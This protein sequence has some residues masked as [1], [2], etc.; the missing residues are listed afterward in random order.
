[1]C[2]A[3]P[4]KIVDLVERDGIAMARLDYGGVT[5]EACMAY[6]PEAEVGDYVLVHVGFAI[7]RI[8]EEE[9]ARTLAL[10]RELGELEL[11]DESREAPEAG[12]P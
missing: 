3:V 12:A 11:P 5:R 2:L 9:A 1:M 4:G 10:L 7:S 8:D 6:L